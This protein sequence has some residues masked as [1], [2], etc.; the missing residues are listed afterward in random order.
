VIFP[1]FYEPV[2]P[3]E[4][5]FTLRNMT[6]DHLGLYRT[7]YEANFKL[8]PRL[9]WDNQRAGGVSWAKRVLMQILGKSEIISWRRTFKTVRKKIEKDQKYAESCF[10]AGSVT[11]TTTG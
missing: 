6:A 4:K 2:L 3:D 5:R 11:A 10:N 8:V 9:I 7:C 1:V